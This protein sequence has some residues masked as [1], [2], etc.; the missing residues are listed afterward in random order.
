MLTRKLLFTII[1]STVLLACQEKSTS[2]WTNIKLTQDVPS[3]VRLNLGD[4]LEDH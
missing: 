2:S 3:L 4:S 1:V